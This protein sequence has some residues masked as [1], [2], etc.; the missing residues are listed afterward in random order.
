MLVRTTIVLLPPFI[1]IPS[2]LFPIQHP[3]L[4]YNK[5]VPTRSTVPMS[6]HFTASSL[7]IFS[8][9]LSRDIRLPLITF[10]SRPLSSVSKWLLMYNHYHLDHN[11]TSRDMVFVSTIHIVMSMTRTIHRSIRR[12]VNRWS[13]IFTWQKWLFDCTSTCIR[14]VM[15][16]HQATSESSW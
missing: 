4:F 6:V 1:F 2:L 8:V 3:L 15:V 7:I 12:L 14:Q 10:L 16:D 13:T 11:V 9:S 5:L